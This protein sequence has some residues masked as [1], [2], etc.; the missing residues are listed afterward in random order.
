M[1][2]ARRSKPR[3]YRRPYRK[4]RPASKKYVRAIVKRAVRADPHY[5]DSTTSDT[6][7]P[8]ADIGAFAQSL[9][10]CVQGDTQKN[11]TG[12]MIQL[13]SLQ[14]KGNLYRDPSSTTHDRVR[15]ILYMVKTPN[16]ASDI[17][18][19]LQ[20]TNLIG[21]RQTDVQAL[22]RIDDGLVSN[23]KVIRDWYIDLGYTG[24]DK[25][26]RMVNYYKK[27]KRPLRIWFDASTD[28]NPVRNEIILSAISDSG[29]GNPLLGFNCRAVFLP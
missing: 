10:P 18:D 12:K 29:T 21:N 17:R 22:R 24:S 28:V 2:Y 3:S 25:Q 6:G 19:V 26:T 9:T 16:G 11:R 1:P 7:V 5:I 13:T 15:M 20:T 27:F 14:I 4:A 23:Y 8:T